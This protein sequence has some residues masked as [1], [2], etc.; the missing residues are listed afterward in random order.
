MQSVKARRSGIS[1]EQSAEAIRYVWAGGC[2][3]Q[4]DR[5]VMPQASVH[6]AEVPHQG[7]TIGR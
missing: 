7:A 6:P 4:A 1:A 2:Q 3:V 5:E